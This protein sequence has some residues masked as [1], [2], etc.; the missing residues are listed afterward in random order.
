MFPRD[1]NGSSALNHAS[2]REHCSG[3]EWPPGPEAGSQSR[4]VLWPIRLRQVHPLAEELQASLR[5]ARLP[6]LILDGDRIPK[7]VSTEPGFSE[8]DRHENIR[9]SAEITRVLIGEGLFVIGAFVTPLRAHREMV[10]RILGEENVLMVFVSASTATCVKR[11][12]KGL[13]RRL[14]AGPAPAAGNYS[15]FEEPDPADKTLVVDTEQKSKTQAAEQ[16]RAAVMAT[17]VKA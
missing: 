8:A 4:L 5:A 12:P 11:D 9:R 7:A 3:C 14:A 2:R 13:Y 17:L 16:V 6:A 15:R 1:G 10:A